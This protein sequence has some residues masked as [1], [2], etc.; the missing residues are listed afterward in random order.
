MID[1]IMNPPAPE[2][3]RAQKTVAATRSAL[4]GQGV[5]IGMAIGFLMGVVAS[6]IR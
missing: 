6:L 3:S 2:P 4:K 5:A 1:P